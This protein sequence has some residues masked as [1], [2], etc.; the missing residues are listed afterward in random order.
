MAPRNFL[1]ESDEE[2]QAESKSPKGAHTAFSPLWCTSLSPKAISPLQ[3]QCQDSELT[4]PG[5]GTDKSTVTDQT[6][7]S[8]ELLSNDIRIE[9]VEISLNE[10]CTEDIMMPNENVVYFEDNLDFEEENNVE[11]ERK[12]SR[13][14]LGK[15]SLKKKM[16]NRRNK[17][18]HGTQIDLN[19]DEK[20]NDRRY[21]EKIQEQDGKLVCISC[22]KMKVSRFD[23]KTARTH[24][25]HCG[26]RTKRKPNKK[27]KI[28]S[29]AF[30]KETFSSN[31]EKN[32]HHNNTHNVIVHQ[33]FTC[34]RK[35]KR[36]EHLVRHIIVKHTN[37]KKPYSCGTCKKTFHEKYNLKCHEKGCP[38]QLPKHIPRTTPNP[39]DQGFQVNVVERK[40]GTA[41]E[42]VIFL[43]FN[44]RLDLYK[45][46]EEGKLKM[47]ISHNIPFTIKQVIC[48]TL[49]M[50]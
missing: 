36:R 2:N 3:E 9:E 34:E 5:S 24:A 18:I 49:I 13:K 10:E 14:K 20:E 15:K 26:E 8:W 42:K 33:C 38:S 23:E 7:G 27:I 44:R 43:T 45:L 46:S 32:K 50:D 17:K 25:I 21:A 16:K 47:M 11:D 1:S 35:F 37:L 28:V 40:I 31:K 48:D 19:K 12:N 29:C 30:C 22:N 39:S 4:I 6:V 41:W